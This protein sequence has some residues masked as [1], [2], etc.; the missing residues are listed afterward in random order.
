MI[1]KTSALLFC[2]LFSLIIIAGCGKDENSVIVGDWIPTTA[3]FDGETVQYSELGLEDG[4]FGFTFTSDGKCT[5][6]LAGVT[7]KGTYT[8]NE[9]SV[10][11]NINDKI[12]KLSYEN[13]TLTLT[14]HYGTSVA[15]FTFTKVK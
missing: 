11:V 13:N 3:S 14:L 8:F 7:G 4:Q 6:T 10:D 2:V 12:Q 1:K 5:A 9:T 15:T